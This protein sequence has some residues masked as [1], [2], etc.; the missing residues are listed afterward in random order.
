MNLADHYDLRLGDHQEQVEKRLEEWQENRFADRLWERDHTLWAS[1]PL[2]EL[3]DRLGWLDL[4]GEM[5]DQVAD[6]ENFSDSIRSEGFR[7]ILLLGMGGSSLAPEVFQ[8]TF[9][10]T[11]GYPA[12]RVLDSTHPE[13]VQ[14]VTEEIDLE[15]T[16]FVVSSKSGG[17][18]E[19]I[20]FFRYFYSLL[21]ELSEDPGSHFVA[22]TDPGSSL[23]DL[24][25]DHG[26]RRVFETPPEVGG[27]YSALTFF[28]LV[29][30]ALIGV[31]TGKLLASARVIAKT[32]TFAAPGP[33]NPALTL[34]AMLGEMALNG[35]DKV[36]FMASPSLTAFPAWL[37]QLI[38]ESTGKEGHGIVPVADE[39]IGE[40][41]AYGRD[42]LFVAFSLAG[43][44][45]PA[46][47]SLFT[48]LEEK[49][50]PVLRIVL[51]E[52]EDLGRE[53]YAWEIAVA[54]AGS[55]MGIN[56]F[57]QPDVQLAKDLARQAMSGEADEGPS[58][59]EFG[60]ADL[61]ELER[62]VYHWAR[63]AKAGDYFSLQIWLPPSDRLSDRL[64][65]LQTF[66]RDRRKLAATVGYGPRFLHSTGQLHKGGPDRVLVLQLVDDTAVDLPVPDTDYSFGSLARAQ[67]IGDYR[68]LSQRGR[69]ILRINLGRDR[70]GALSALEQAA[71]MDRT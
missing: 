40:P 38:A 22:I 39:P 60:T 2:P 20:S 52:K 19:T 23:S 16:L 66:L 17:T 3:T 36:T 4:P 56:P 27:R 24:A 61:S 34:G 71:G 35:R 47:D 12:L 70:D 59:E 6:L 13:A 30:A 29:P 48:A 64:Q 62:A 50:H 54:A 5:L 28:G 10:N 69:R 41:E 7:H 68:A 15:T 25:R 49:G 51:D 18:V 67:S 43:E 32:T 45:G 55:V 33:A 26:F 58:L 11:D 9:G 21:K 57:D 65:S 37:E 31:D 44:E 14:N 53:M 1:N 8:E 42:R 46:D 63:Q